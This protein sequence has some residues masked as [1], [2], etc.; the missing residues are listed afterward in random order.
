MH[1]RTVLLTFFTGVSMFAFLLA[2]SPARA[3]SVTGKLTS[4]DGATDISNAYVSLR[5]DSWVFYQSTNTASDGSFSFSNVPECTCVLQVY[6]NSANYADPDDQKVTISGSATDLGKIKMAEHNILGKLVLSDGTTPVTGL[7]ATFRS[8]DYVTYRYSTSN[9]TTGEVRFRVPTTGTYILTIWGS[10]TKDG[11]T[12]WPPA[13]QTVTI[14]DLSQP[15]NLGNIQFKTANV[16]GT[17]TETDGTTGIANAWVTGRTDNW[18]TSRSTQTASNGSFGIYMPEG[19][20]YKLD[21]YLPNSSA[22]NPDS[23]SFTVP[24]TGTTSL[25]VIKKVESNVFFKVTKPDGV[26][27]IQYAGV[28]AHKLDWSNS[29]YASTDSNG[30]ASMA[31]TSAGTYK[32]E[33]WTNNYVDN[34]DPFE[35]TYSSGTLYFDG[36]NGSSV[37]K[38]AGP[39]MQ[40]VIRTHDGTNVSGASLSLYNDTYTTY[41]WGSSDTSGA[42]TLPAVPS[43]KY[44]LQISPPYDLKGIVAPDPIEVNLTRNETYNI[45][46]ITLEKARKTVRGKVTRDDGTAVPNAYVS[47][48]KR[49]GQGWTQT[50]TNTSGEFTFVVGSGSWDFSVYPKYDYTTQPDWGY[51]G[52]P[53]SVTFEKDNSTEES[54]TKDVTVEGFTAT[55]T[56]TLRNPDGS[57]PGGSYTSLSAWRQEGGGNYAN[58]DSNGKVTIKLPAGTFNVY[59]YGSDSRYASPSIAP[60]TLKA[61]EEK[62]LGT[63]SFLE[64]NSSIT[65]KVVDSNNNGLSG[66]SVSAWKLK[67]GDYGWTTTD[68]NGNYTLYLSPGTYNVDAWP[69]YVPYG[70]SSNATRYSRVEKPKEVLLNAKE[71]KTDVNFTFAIT[72]AKI[73]G[74]VKKGND[75]I[76]DL[77]GW[78]N[79]MRTDGDPDARSYDLG[80]EVSGGKWEVAVPAGTYRVNVWMPYGSGYTAQS[81]ETVTVSS[82][83]T[84]TDVVVKAIPNDVTVTGSV[85][86]AEGNVLK[87][88]WGSIY[89]NNGGGGSQWA[90]IDKGTYTLKLSAG[91]WKFSHWIDTRYGYMRKPGEETELTFTSGEART[92]DLTLLKLDS[93]V[94]VKTVDPNGKVLPNVWVTLNTELAG[95]RKRDTYDF[96]RGNITLGA[97]TNTDG[98]AEIKAP[99]GDY[100]VSASLPTSF[101]YINPKTE[102]V[103]IASDKSANLTFKFRESTGTVTGTVS[104]GHDTTI[105]SFRA[106]NHVTSPG[107]VTGWTEGG[108]AEVFTDSGSYALNVT[109]DQDWR[110]SAVYQS[111]KTI[112]RSKEFVVRPDATTGTIVQNL[113]MT[114]SAVTMPSA[115]TSTFPSTTT[116]ALTLEDGATVNMPQ[117]SLLTNG[118]QV[119]VTV[120][121]DA[122]LPNTETTDVV[123][124]GYDLQA[125]QAS[126]TNATQ[127]ITNFAQEVTLTL[128]YTDTQLTEA[129]VKDEHDLDVKYWDTTTGSWKAVENEVPNDEANTLTATTDHFTTFAITTSTPAA[130]VPTIELTSPENGKAVTKNDVTLSGSVTDAKATLT[131]TLNGGSAQTV[132]VRNDGTFT[133]TVSPLTEGTNTIVVSATNTAGSAKSITRTVEYTPSSTAQ[134]GNGNGKDAATAKRAKY[135]VVS[136]QSG[137]SPLITVLNTKGKVVK[138]F[139]AFAK[140]LRA[141]VRTVV[142]DLNDDGVDEIVAYVTNGSSEVRVF[143]LAGKRSARFVAFNKKFADG[144]R[145]AVGDMNGDGQ[146]EIVVAAQKGSPLVAIYSAK[147]KLIKQFT[148][149]PKDFT[150]GLQILLGDFDGDD[151]DDLLVAQR[152]GGTSRASLY[153]IKGKRGTTFFLFDKKSTVPFSLTTADTNGDGK[154]EIVAVSGKGVSPVIRLINEKGKVIK[155]LH[156]FTKTLTTG[157]AVTAADVTGDGKDELVVTPSGYGKP[158]VKV[159]GTAKKATYSW[160]P[161]GNTVLAGTTTAA[162]DLNN[163]GKEEVLVAPLAKRGLAIKVFTSSGKFSKNLLPYGKTFSGGYNISASE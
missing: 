67:G 53:I 92:V 96:Y 95:E 66:Q 98:E 80:G 144:V 10:F 35:F 37:V 149:E 31:I 127:T 36:T 34:P 132:T 128:P 108:F 135:I 23:V 158:T 47:A 161:F 160:D 82:G 143:S 88:I 125:V 119:T 24:A 90:S 141:D 76:T 70:Q 157:L 102:E 87:D 151:R 46:T 110:V 2:A 123:S 7:G 38:A 30:L 11:V 50:E 159:Y 20:S 140:S 136:P 18:S 113:E 74:V 55:L 13:D 5:T 49:S 154:E 29:R 16:T 48:W 65:G 85:K 54:V 58:A 41:K 107:Y 72:D 21:V 106:L 134:P 100:F 42:F 121:P 26:T 45:G 86:D 27:A 15:Y 101:G 145:V 79:A 62:N 32:V 14:T 115:A 9:S 8:S 59:V 117:N 83:Q 163:D 52:S 94:Q 137:S 81:E 68:A 142:T 122:K 64:K 4:P 77:Y 57:V 126:G 129:G 22:N 139:L 130:V 120:T 131:Y 6:A 156:P 61:K 153:T 105:S 91:T 148:A 40:G 147:G 71:A 124:Y 150:G 3:T 99:A 152:E 78:A 19:G 89:T 97:Y 56:A 12:Y 1:R 114:Q 33:V 133:T 93:A 28:S 73:S 69:A 43:G 138:Q 75:I 146:K 51:Y 155:T 103:S 25:G 116:K 109:K 112:W 17:I 60:V 44:K 104:L 111:G 118:E 162:I 63:L 84:V 39:S